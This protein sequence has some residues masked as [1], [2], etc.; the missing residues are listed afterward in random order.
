MSGDVRNLFQSKPLVLVLLLL[1][2]LPLLLLLLPLPILR[3]Q[4]DSHPRG[5][6][7]PFIGVFVLGCLSGK[8]KKQ[9]KV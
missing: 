1:L 7:F 3:S 6:C 9:L 2:L 8:E 5:A 4:L